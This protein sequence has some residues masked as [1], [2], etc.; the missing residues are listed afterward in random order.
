MANDTQAH[1]FTQISQAGK[2]LPQHQFILKPVSSQGR[3]SY[4]VSERFTVY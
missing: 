1:L 2:D 4:P 3:V